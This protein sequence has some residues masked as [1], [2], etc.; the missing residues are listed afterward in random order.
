MSERSDLEGTKKKLL[1]LK[2]G[3]IEIEVTFTNLM[4]AV[5]YVQFQNSEFS[6]SLEWCV[7][8]DET[9]P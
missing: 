6:S 8:M 3:H 9:R 1:K 5:Y 4:I 7:L 2:S